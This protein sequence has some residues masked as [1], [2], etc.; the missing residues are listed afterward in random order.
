MGPD[1]DMLER[2]QKCDH[3]VLFFGSGDYYVM[4]RHCSRT[5]VKTGMQSDDA[6]PMFVN[7]TITGEERVEL[8]L[9][10]IKVTIEDN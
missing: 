6:D 10:N 8:T 1:V 5:W 3:P 9:D 2:Q 7:D 4:C